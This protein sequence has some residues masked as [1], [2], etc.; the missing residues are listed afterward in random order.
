MVGSLDITP[1]R[2]LIAVADNGGFLRAA[3][4]LHLSQAAVSQHVRRLEG[5]IGR[6]LVE[7][8]GR[9]SRFT[10]DGEE[11]LGYARRIV[12]LHDAAVASFTRPVRPA[13]TIGSTE[14]AAAQLLPSLTR[15]L[16]ATLLDHEIRLRLDRG[17][18]LRED[19]AAGRL[20]VAVLPGP[21]P[22]EAPDLAAVLPLG[23]LELTWY[24]APGWVLPQ[25]G[26]S[27][28]IAAFENPCALRTRA[29]TT[30][31]EHG[32][33]ATIAAEATQLAGVQAAVAAGVGVALL[34]TLG[35]A[36]EGLVARHDLPQAAPME[37]SVWWRTG[38]DPALGARVADALRRVIPALPDAAP[39][40]CTDHEP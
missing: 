14:H 26:A 38:L 21:A 13:L 10:R 32:I 4:A 17:A 37:F 28:P 12:T 34:A 35:Q 33:Q 20:D 36:P 5:A 25:R 11:L 22:A 31:S 24:A 23:L 3:E 40:T 29:L 8:H 9:G 19:L 30:L 18:R 27:V 2:S 1:L 16:G 7:R 15:E 6:P 39:R